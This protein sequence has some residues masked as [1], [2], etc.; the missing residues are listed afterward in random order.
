MIDLAEQQHFAWLA[1]S[2]G[3]TDYLPLT[4]SDLEALAGAGDYVEKYPGTHLF[5]EGAPAVAAYVIQKGNVELYRTRTEGPRVVGHVKAAGVI[6][7]IAMFQ[8][9]PY[10]SSARAV[11]PVTAFRLERDRLLPVLLE[12]PRLAMRWLV[13][14]LA[15]LESTQRRVIRLMHR[16]VKEQ[17]A[18]L[19]LE[20]ADAF[21]EVNLSQAS[22][23]TLLG[24]SRQ[25][26]NEA[27]A[28][29][30]REGIADTGYRVVRVLDRDRLCEL[31]G[32]P[33]GVC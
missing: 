19:L 22:L 1:R 16:T 29:L 20:E 32:S 11:G 3:R 21:G 30:R 13:A 7:D 14:G 26:V 23:A 28:D 31:V 33:P 24:A 10:I 17:V 27:L 4:G 2:F 15:Q 25:S 6:G 12:H 9:E 8:N 18:E 5:K